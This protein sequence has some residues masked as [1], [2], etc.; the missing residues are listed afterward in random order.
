MG[1][2]EKKKEA[3]LIHPNS[4]K[5]TAL[6][7]KNIRTARREAKKQQGHQHLRLLAERLIWFRDHLDTDKRKYSVEETHELIE[8]YI[9]RQEAEAC[10]GVPLV[11]QEDLV[12]VDENINSF[13]CVDL[14]S[15]EAVLW[16]RT[17][18]GQVKLVPQVK[19][20]KFIRGRLADP[21]ES[22]ASKDGQEMAGDVD[23]TPPLADEDERKRR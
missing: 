9:A 2:L 23:D 11:S 12:K 3:K 7:K 13:E 16:L 4:R 1:K 18:D 6:V 10:S 8:R 19:T 21:A 22:S 17:W 20:H 14:T 5:A 15:E